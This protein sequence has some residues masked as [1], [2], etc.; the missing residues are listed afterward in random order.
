[1]AHPTQPRRTV[2]PRKS[3]RGVHLLDS[4]QPR[5]QAHQGIMVVLGDDLKPGP[6][7]V[8]VRVKRASGPVYVRFDSSAGLPTA[9][10][11]VLRNWYVD[12]GT[13]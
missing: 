7:T 1:M 8:H 12:G 13:K 6:H 5:L 2:Q 10:E 9:T 4:A 11:P 3:A